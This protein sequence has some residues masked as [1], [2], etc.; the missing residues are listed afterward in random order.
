VNNWL[1]STVFDLAE[2]RGIEAE[3]AL[4]EAKEL[5]RRSSKPS[6]AEFERVDQKLRRVLGDVDPFWI[7][8]SY[9][10]EQTRGEG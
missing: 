1:T 2:P 4:D 9:H 3:E 6:L 7:C 10:L 8:W 5:L